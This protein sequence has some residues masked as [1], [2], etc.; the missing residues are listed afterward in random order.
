[1]AK[2][3]ESPIPVDQRYKTYVKV[4]D[5]IEDYIQA[6]VFICPTLVDYSD[7]EWIEIGAPLL[8]LFPEIFKLKPRGARQWNPWFPSGY[9]GNLELI[10]LLNKAINICRDLIKENK[11]D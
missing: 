2:I 8:S 3:N 7:V 1:M 9:N 11:N 4:R 6:K 5:H 10:I